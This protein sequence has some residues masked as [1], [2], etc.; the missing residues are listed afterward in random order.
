MRRIRDA[1]RNEE[2]PAGRL[3]AIDSDQLCGWFS[4]E[5]HIPLDMIPR[6]VIGSRIFGAYESAGRT[7]DCTVPLF[8]VG[9][10]M[11]TMHGAAKRQV[12][13]IHVDGALGYIECYDMDKLRSIADEHQR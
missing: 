3:L 12:R 11:V 6:F 4:C 1:M 2:L 5:E 7:Y 9:N 13:L 8:Y 10:A